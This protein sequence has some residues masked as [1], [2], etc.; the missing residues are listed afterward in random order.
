MRGSERKAGSEWGG[1]GGEMR[2]EVKGRLEV[3]G[4]GLKVKWGGIG[5]E[6]GGWLKMGS[7]RHGT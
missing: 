7:V 3:N 5:G 4:Y 1:I 2:G 6:W